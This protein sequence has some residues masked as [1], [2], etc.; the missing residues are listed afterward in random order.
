MMYSLRSFLFSLA[1]MGSLVSCTLTE[2]PQLSDADV[3]ENW[4]GPVVEEADIWPETDWWNAFNDEE[5]SNIISQVQENNL[6]L[7]NNRRN[8]ESAQI[9]LREAGF[10]L[11]PTPLVNLGTG[12]SYN[13]TR[14]DGSETSSSPN[15][16][17]SLGATFTYNDI[18]S[19]P[20]AYDR[21]VADYDF[22]VAQVADVALNT[23]GTAASTYFQLLL[24]RDKV[25][26]SMQN[27]ENAEAIYRI[28]Q[29][30]VD[31]GV[32]VPIE[33]LQQQIALDRE[34]N[35]LR[36]FIQNDLA[37]RSSLALLLGR[38]LQ[39]F[40]VA[41]QTLQNI[42]VPLVKPGLPSELLVRRPDLVQAEANL[43]SARASVDIVKTD[44]F[45]QISLTGGINASSTSLSELVSDPDT[46]LNI[47][48]NLIQTLLDNGQRFRNI[49]QARITMENNLNN[50][51]RAVIGA[52]NEVE[53]LLSNIELLEAQ[54]V[55]A[56]QNLE[57][58]EEAFRIAELRYQE[59]V[60]DFQTVLIAQNTLF[61]TRN[62]Y[63][64]NKLL[65]LNTI[66][67]L[68]QALGGGWQAEE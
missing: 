7:E 50:Y 49:D 36:S 19:K 29:A 25:E 51:R 30:R 1:C 54:G 62:S 67:G 20:A 47:N 43:R 55:V 18:L 60:A 16:P 28:A 22:R 2:L 11:L 39:N 52:F 32:A 31:A 13:E 12:A 21:A 42:E 6:D 65:R 37:T 66:T 63:L 35:N 23:L 38:S 44:L 53:V 4:Q 40:E 8:L 9:A 34:R 27:V 45:P 46:I 5:L 14:V 56:L 24:T 15:E 57:A 41:G 64:D 17:F 33:A 58:A 48:A 26:A 61:S 10:N 59:G 68:F 3:P